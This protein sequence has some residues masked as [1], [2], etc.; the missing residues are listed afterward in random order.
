MF[1][2]GFVF[3]VENVLPHTKI[4]SLTT[5]PGASYLRCRIDNVIPLCV[6]REIHQQKK[7]GREK[8]EKK[9]EVAAVTLHTRLSLLNY[10]F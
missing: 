7:P 4:N 1:E 10:F 3:L 9:G 2:A 8:S 5:P 6:R